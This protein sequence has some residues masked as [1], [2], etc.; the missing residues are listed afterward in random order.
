MPLSGKTK[1]R[2]V[3]GLVAALLVFVSVEALRV[4]WFRGY[5]RG[6]RTGVIRKISYKG[7]PYCKYMMGEMALQGTLPG[8]PVEIWEFSVDDEKPS[9]PLVVKLHEAERSAERVTLQY[10]QDLHS[11]FRCTPSEYFITGIEK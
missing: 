8:Q 11:L 10:R 7:P 1:L 2:I 9:N 6:T 4:W 3:L 5:S